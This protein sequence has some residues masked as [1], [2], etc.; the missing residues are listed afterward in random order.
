VTEPNFTSLREQ[1]KDMKWIASFAPVQELRRVQIPAPAIAPVIDIGV[2][3]Y[4][5]TGL[6]IV[7]F[8]PYIDV[9]PNAV[10]N[11]QNI[12]LLLGLT[13]EIELNKVRRLY[14]HFPDEFITFVPDGQSW[15][16]TAV[17]NA[18]FLEMTIRKVMPTY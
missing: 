12:H 17:T 4:T 1:M 16:C 8:R 6:T 14:R 5:G 11:P 9:D 3:V 7:E 10:A 2:Q 13:P 18:G 15:Y